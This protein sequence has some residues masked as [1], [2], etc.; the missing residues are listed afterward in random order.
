MS[1]E[2]VA[3]CG[4]VGA[5]CHDCVSVPGSNKRASGVNLSRDSQMIFCGKE[6]AFIRLDTVSV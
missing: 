2:S 5:A 4:G 3:E 6:D 1:V